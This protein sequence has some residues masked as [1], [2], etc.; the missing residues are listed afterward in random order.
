MKKNI[1]KNIA[2]YGLIFSIASCY[3]D[4]KELTHDSELKDI[5]DYALN[6]SYDNNNLAP[7]VDYDAENDYKFDDTSYRKNINFLQNKTTSINYQDNKGQ[8]LLM[9]L[10][11]RD[12]HNKIMKF[13]LE[14]LFADLNLQNRKGQ[15]ALHFAVLAG[16]IFM[17]KLLLQYN[18]LLDIQDHEGKTPLFYAV[19]KNHVE[20]AELLLQAGANRQLGLFEN[21]EL[22][23]DKAHS[24]AMRAVF[25]QKHTAIS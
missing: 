20:I 22:P 7:V 13:A 21:E 5:A 3:A 19:E 2:F 6:P 1:I 8:T 16:N 18:A 10:A 23:Q 4:I 25:K 14:K 24:L 17:V 11:E 9:L 15:T 12:E